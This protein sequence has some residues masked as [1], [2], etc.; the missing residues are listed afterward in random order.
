MKQIVALRKRPM[1]NGGYSLF[2]DY[3]IDDTRV[4]EMLKLY[5]VPENSRRDKQLN[6]ETMAVAST[7]HAKKILELQQG[8]AGI[9]KRKTDMLLVDYLDS[10]AEEYRSA[11]SIMHAGTVHYVSQHIRTWKPRIK[12]SGMTEDTAVRFI[13]YLRS[14]NLSN[15]SIRLYYA[16]LKTQ[17]GV[18]VKRK[19]ISQNK[20]IYVDHADLPKRIDASKEYLTVEEL[21]KLIDTP[22]RN[23]EYKRALS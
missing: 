7:M 14:T 8:M 23:G 3:Y 1:K 10:R 13:E 6:Q 16:V 18:A 21:K 9:V 12:L 22:C 11:G 2:L 4:K 15:S 19:L 5:L 20:M 17:I